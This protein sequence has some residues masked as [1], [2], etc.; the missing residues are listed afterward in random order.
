MDDA[1]WREMVCTNHYPASNWETLCSNT[2]A[3]DSDNL[4]MFL[5]FM[6]VIIIAIVLIAMINRKA[7][8]PAILVTGKPT[9]EPVQYYTNDYA[10]SWALG[11][12]LFL[13]CWVPV[14]NLILFIALIV[15]LFNAK[16]IVK[17]VYFEKR[18]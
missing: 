14:L 11:I 8:S 1:T 7:V 2:P 3:T 15:A 16:P 5:L 12:A 17:T 10:T 18:G 13:F 9:Y 6:P 4:G